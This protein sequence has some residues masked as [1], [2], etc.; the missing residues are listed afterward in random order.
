MKVLFTFIHSV[1]LLILF[2]IQMKINV[3]CEELLH[4]RGQFLNTTISQLI[5]NGE[6]FKLKQYVQLLIEFYSIKGACLFIISRTLDSEIENTASDTLFREKSSGQLLFTE[7]LQTVEK[8]NLIKLIK[9]SVEQIVATDRDWEIDSDRVTEDRIQETKENVKVLIGAAET[10]ISQSRDIFPALKP[11]TKKIFNFM[12]ERLKKFHPTVN[13]ETRISSFVFLYVLIPMMISVDQYQLVGEISPNQ[14][15]GFVNLS[16]L[17]QQIASDTE[18]KTVTSYSEQFN[19]F[20]INNRASML[21]AISSLCIDDPTITF[22]LPKQKKDT[23][24][25]ESFVLSQ[26]GYRLQAESKISFK[27]IRREA[28]LVLLIGGGVLG[29][30]LSRLLQKRKEYE[31]VLL[32]KKDYFESAAAVLRTFCNPEMID[33]IRVPHKDYL[34]KGTLVLGQA[35]VLQ[36]DRVILE[37]GQE[38]GFD[39]VVIGTGSYYPSQIKNERILSD[40]RA[41]ILSQEHVTL[42]AATSILI[43]GGGPVGVELAGEIIVKYPHKKIT[44]VTSKPQ[45]LERL[46]QRTHRAAER[47]LSSRGV[48]IVLN[49]RARLIDA[50]T[51]KFSQE[52]N[53]RIFDRIYQC[54]GPI[55]R[56]SLLDPHLTKYITENKRI[57]VNEF[58]QLPDH[59]NIFCGGDAASLREERTAERAV[60]HSQVIFK[61]LINIHKGKT[62]VNYSPPRRPPL[63]CISLGP[64]TAIMVRS[65]KHIS[66][67]GTAARMKLFFLDYGV[68]KLRKEKSG[69]K[70]SSWNLF[71]HSKDKASVTLVLL[72]NYLMGYMI[73]S[74]LQD[75][76]SANVKV[77][78]LPHE[79][80]LD[81]QQ[82]YKRELF[83]LLQK[84]ELSH[85]DKD[86]SK[87]SPNDLSGKGLQLVVNVF[88]E[89]DQLVK[90]MAEFMK[91]G[92]TTFYCAPINS[93]DF[94]DDI[95]SACRMCQIPRLVYCHRGGLPTFK[96]L[97]TPTLDFIRTQTK[98]EK[99]DLDHEFAVEGLKIF[100][101]K[102]ISIEDKIRKSVVDRRIIV[103]HS[104][105]FQDVILHHSGRILTDMILP[106][107][108]G[109][110]QLSWVDVR[111]VAGFLVDSFFRDYTDETPQKEKVKKNKKEKDDGTLVFT[112]SG[113]EFISA[114]SVSRMLSIRLNQTLDDKE[115]TA[116]EI[117][118]MYLNDGFSEQVAKELTGIAWAERAAPSLTSTLSQTLQKDISNFAQYSQSI[119]QMLVD[120]SL[121]DTTTGPGQSYNS[122]DEVPD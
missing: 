105:F 25:D 43:V 48:E 7:Y 76:P 66:T 120:I 55:S 83:R 9:P 116:K 107:I 70:G 60:K 40:F 71:S 32:D 17:L 18:T 2:Q 6:F 104:P 53:S 5:K 61:N 10:L 115:L 34:K 16:K 98:A 72:C 45:L 119:S 4:P 85:S 21:E 95:L 46:D 100:V 99:D 41:E 117:Y 118:Q 42:E 84:Q 49:Q 23:K 86:K 38:I 106:Q 79:D 96:L 8:D 29:T 63:M 121:E 28:K 109:L 73:A 111:E 93:K 69:K 3:L 65:G 47:F 108:T 30:T 67:S 77:G 78:I 15:K 114:S 12:N 37:D 74:E 64:D 14:R 54:S 88:K 22:D 94:T 90:E 27:R 101:D 39:Y 20:V 110:S 89:S 51:A 62:L 81:S 82:H 80:P 75:Y 24:L 36:Q 97:E 103:R 68:N 57:M 113:S 11:E 31:V 50:H 87:S 112:T 13:S 26:I 102:M 19:L 59:P 33:K 1:I 35:Q 52:E 92:E 122:Y 91:G 44:L 56:C 58:L